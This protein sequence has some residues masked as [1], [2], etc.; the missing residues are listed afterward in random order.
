MVGVVTT[1]EVLSHPI[2]TI[3]CFEGGVFFKGVGMVLDAQADNVGWFI[4]ENFCW[5]ASRH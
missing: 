5:S 4:A 1:R 3:Q 2:F